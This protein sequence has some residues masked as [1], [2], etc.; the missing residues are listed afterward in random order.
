VTAHTRA[1]WTDGMAFK[2]ELE[3][4]SCMM[5]ADERFGGR[6]LGPRPKSLLLAGL[7]GCTG[8]DVV[9][10]L[11]KMKMEWDRFSLEVE[12]QTAESDPKVYT[13]IL[14]KYIFSGG[15]LERDKIEKAVK[16]SQEKYCPVSAM[17]G[18]TARIAT[19]I[20]LNPSQ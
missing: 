14:V 3:G 2:A 6:N 9:S 8:M 20:V 15:R 16:L 19:E 7:A 13:G 12:G 18:K 5:D 1:T 4:H 17:L 10:L 11:R